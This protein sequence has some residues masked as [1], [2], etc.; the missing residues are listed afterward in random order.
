MLPFVPWTLRPRPAQGR[1]AAVLAWLE[2]EARLIG[3]RALRLET[4]LAN[5]RAVQF[6]LAHGYQRTENFG[7]YAGNPAAACFEKA[8]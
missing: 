8:L 4:R 7:R 3:Y 6:Y 5:L 2:A 1:D